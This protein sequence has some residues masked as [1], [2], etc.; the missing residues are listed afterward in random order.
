MKDYVSGC[1]AA[2]VDDTPLVDLNSLEENS[3]APTLILAIQPNLD[4][5]VLFLT[6]SR[7][8]LDNL[9]KLLEA[10]RRG[11]TDIAVILQRTIKEA[12]T[13]QAVKFA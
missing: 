10:A 1:L 5:V 2:F 9:E 4:Q 8:H 6:E 3:N 12:L 13:E 7:L 11:C